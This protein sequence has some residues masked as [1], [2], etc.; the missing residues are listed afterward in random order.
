MSVIPG[1]ATSPAYDETKTS[2]GSKDG[3]PVRPTKNEEKKD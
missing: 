3:E 1:R 2:L